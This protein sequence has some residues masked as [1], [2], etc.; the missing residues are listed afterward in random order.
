MQSS[1]SPSQQV[2]NELYGLSPLTL[3]SILQ[4]LDILVGDNDE[5]LI[6]VNPA[7]AML[8]DSVP[9]YDGD[10]GRAVFSSLCREVSP[11][12]FHGFGQTENRLKDFQGSECNSIS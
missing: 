1:L 7:V 9:N 8:D 3:L 2:R 6:V 10:H 4:I 5:P 12:S 11:F